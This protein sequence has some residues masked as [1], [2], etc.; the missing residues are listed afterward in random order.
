MSTSKHDSQP[1]VAIAASELLAQQSALLADAARAIPHRFDACTYALGYI[2]QPVHLC[3][4]CTPVPETH[5]YKE[6][7]EEQAK[8]KERA[9]VCAACS[10]ACH[11]E[12]EQVELFSKRAFRC[13]CP[14][15][16]MGLACTL[17]KL[18]IEEGREVSKESSRGGSGGMDGKA[19]KGKGRKQEEEGDEGIKNTENRYG[20]NFW[21]RFCRCGR[22]YD[23]EREKEA[24]IQCL[25]CE[26]SRRRIFSLPM[27]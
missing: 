19:G 14:T 12:H 16:K 9:G 6:H 20:Q 17:V 22:P 18:P 2:R 5:T 10:V 25:S 7:A 3:L 8:M 21:D 15:A 27:L 26:V 1:E 4:T 24:M 11:G 23:P 13:D